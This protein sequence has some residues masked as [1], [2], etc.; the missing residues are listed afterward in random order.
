MAAF[1]SLD[2]TRFD[3]WAIVADGG[4]TIVDVAHRQSCYEWLK[5][6]EYAVLSID[7]AD[8]ISPAVAAMGKLF[9]WE[10][11]FGYSLSPESRNLNALRD[12]FEFE[13]KGGQGIVFELLE[14]S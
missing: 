7:F 11:Q 13:V 1:T 9:D 2:F 5:R 8:G 12:G 6:E 14:R 3:V 10:N 4:V